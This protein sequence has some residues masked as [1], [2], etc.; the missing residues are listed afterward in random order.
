M[1]AQCGIWR[2][3]PPDPPASRY[4]TLSLLAPLTSNTCS[5]I[6]YKS[7]YAYYMNS[8]EET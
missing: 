3:V 2:A 6:V 1:I 5:I 7:S 4:S 8:A